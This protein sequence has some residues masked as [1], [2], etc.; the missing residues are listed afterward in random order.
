MSVRVSA[1]DNSEAKGRLKKTVLFRG[2]SDQEIESC[3]ECSKAEIVYFRKDEN[4]FSEGDDPAGLLILLD[5]SVIL[6]R[7]D[8]D[9]KRN[10]LAVVEKPGE[11]F[12]YETLFLNEKQYGMYAIA[13]KP[14]KV[15]VMP[16]N[17]LV[18]TCER[19]CD[20]H[21]NLISNMMF[22][23]AERSQ[24]LNDRLEVILGGSLR[25]KIAKY[26]LQNISHTGNRVLSMGR[27]EMADYL[28]AT[29]PSLSRELMKMQ[30]EGMLSVSGRQITVLD[31][32]SRT[33]T[34]P[35]GQQEKNRSAQQMNESQT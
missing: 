29:R 12:G 35:Q 10:L 17:F 21:Q 11:L 22:F 1:K 33:E 34:A 3:L 14:S 19:N 25:K 2:L 7:H 8:Y 9:G 4:L 31:Q 6:A 20:F 13:K 18:S 27:Q 16:R 26:L 5:G 32:D 28:N 15:L 24:R 23:M 30:D